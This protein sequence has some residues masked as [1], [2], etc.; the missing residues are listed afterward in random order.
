M[1]LYE[2]VAATMNYNNNE[3]RLLV[4]QTEAITDTSTSK[5]WREV[6]LIMQFVLW[7]ERGARIFRDL[8]KDVQQ[9]AQEV[10]DQLLFTEMKEFKWQGTSKPI[11]NYMCF[12]YNFTQILCLI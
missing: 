6:L 11:L 5:K 7:R 1:A 8:S 4:N 12:F 3:D 9:L 10:A 2:E